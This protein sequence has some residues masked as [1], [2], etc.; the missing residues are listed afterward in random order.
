[1]KEPSATLLWNLSDG[2]VGI[3]P[4]GSGAEISAHPIGSGPFKFVA[5]ETDKEVILER[6]DDYWGDKAKLA[7]VAF[8][9]S[10]RRDHAR[11]RTAQG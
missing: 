2:A 6:N 4:Y 3:V 1:M 11:A 9:R 8:C 7:A 10:A 5:A